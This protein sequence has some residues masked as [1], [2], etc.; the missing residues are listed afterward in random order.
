MGPPK[1]L[2][3]KRGVV[4]VTVVVVV[5]VVVVVA[6]AAAAAVGIVEEI[7]PVPLNHLHVGLVL[8]RN[9]L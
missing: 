7:L 4:T 2:S 9:R 3:H 6:A 1:Q 5:V 8:D